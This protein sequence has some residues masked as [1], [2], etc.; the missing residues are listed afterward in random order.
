MMRAMRRGAWRQNDG[1]DQEDEEEE[2]RPDESPV[3]VRA[4]LHDVD[5]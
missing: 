5:V 3:D 4:A 2:P 1:R